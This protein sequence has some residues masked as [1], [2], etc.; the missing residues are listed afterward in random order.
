MKRL[1]LTEDLMTGIKE[2]DNQHRE[3]LALGNEVLFPDSGE[4]T[5]RD[6]LKVLNFLIKYV[7]IHFDAEELLMECNGFDRLEGHRKQHRRLRREV[8]G[9]ADRA[10]QQGTVKGL[11]NELY[12]L[13]HD[14]YIYHIREWD[15]AMAVYTSKTFQTFK[16][17][18]P[19]PEDIEFN[20]FEI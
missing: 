9:L 7:K 19:E 1:E 16:K 17:T 8:E 20:D 15:K 4:T 13:L 6:I 14:W 2:I 3:L 12:Y 11:A 10:K 18:V 5:D